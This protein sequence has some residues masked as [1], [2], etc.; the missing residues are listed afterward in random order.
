M[1]V[2]CLVAPPDGWTGWTPAALEAWGLTGSSY[3]R[4]LGP[5]TDVD[6]LKVTVLFQLEGGARGSAFPTLDKLHFGRRGLR[7]SEV[8]R[9][10]GEAAKLRLALSQLG[11]AQLISL[12]TYMARLNL[13]APD[14]AFHAQKRAEWKKVVNGATKLRPLNAAEQ[15]YQK[16]THRAANPGKA[17]SSALDLLGHILD[18]YDDVAG[19][20]RSAQ[21]GMLLS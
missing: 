20:A 3:V 15:A 12:R 1:T 10:V 5:A 6:S 17:P 21:C 9:L 14:A 7:S 16:R 2:S 18:A 11:V 19:A 13:G 8:A 4:D